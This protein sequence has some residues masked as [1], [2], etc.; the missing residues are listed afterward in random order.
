MTDAPGTLPPDDRYRARCA[1]L[2]FQHALD[3][4]EHEMKPMSGEMSPE[5]QFELAMMGRVAR[6][7]FT[8]A[9]AEVFAGYWAR[10]PELAKYANG[11]ED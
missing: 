11:R 10:K 7:F 8:M 5:C 3:S 9:N 2:R 1:F 4:L 6:S